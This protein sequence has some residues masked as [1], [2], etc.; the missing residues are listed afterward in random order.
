MTFLSL[1]QFS[2]LP[3]AF[4]WLGFCVWHDLR[5]REVPVWLTLVPLALAALIGILFGRWSSACLL[6]ILVLCSDI[7]F[8]RI[9]LGLLGTIGIILLD[10]VIGL[11]NFS[12]FL[13]WLLWEK[14]A[15]GGAD[16][17]ILI[18]LLLAW[19]NVSLLVW[20]A[21]AGGLQGLVAWWRKQREIPYTV[22]ILIGSIAFWLA[23]IL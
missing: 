5:N 18:S 19:G 13:V 14:G 6:V 7:P 11:L 10:P 4:L 1:L 2:L 21:L 9:G 12:I 8:L 22:A 17:K 20:I 16:A 15:V 23:T 3:F